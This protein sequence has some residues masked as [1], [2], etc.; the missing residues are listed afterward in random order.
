MSEGDGK[1]IAMDLCKDNF[2]YIIAA[3]NSHLGIYNEKEKSF[4]I[5][6]F[7]FRDNFIFEEYHWDTGEPYGTVK[8]LIELVAAPKFEFKEDMLKFLNELNT[9]MRKTIIAANND[10]YTA[11]GKLYMII[12]K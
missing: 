10:F 8:P 11:E 12:D 7:K 3:R 2:I 6:R 9:N 5:S 4:F 1:Y